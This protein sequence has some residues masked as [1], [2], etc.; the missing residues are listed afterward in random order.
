MTL[1]R[2]VKFVIPLGVLLSPPAQAISDAQY[3]SIKALGELNGVALQCG[4][5][6]QTRRMKRVLVATLPKRRALGLAFDDATNES[7]LRF[8]EKNSSCLDEQEFR[9]QV[10]QAIIRLKTEFSGD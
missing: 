6:G 2:F 5:I 8:M 1:G 4:Y 3:G 7:F 10:D 9:G